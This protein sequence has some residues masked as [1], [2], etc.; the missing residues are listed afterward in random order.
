MLLSPISTTP[1][2]ISFFDI[3]MLIRQIKQAFMS[4][5]L[6]AIKVAHL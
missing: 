5:S 3:I 2:L 1:K 4:E 6:C